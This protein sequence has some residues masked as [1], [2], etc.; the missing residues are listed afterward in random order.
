MNQTE[1]SLDVCSEREFSERHYRDRECLVNDFLLNLFDDFVD[2]NL[3]L[4][5]RL[6]LRLLE[7]WK[8]LLPAL[9]PLLRQLL[10]RSD[11]PGIP[12][13]NQPP[14]LRYELSTDVALFGSILFVE[15]SAVFF[16]ILPDLALLLLGEQCTRS[17]TPEELLEAVHD[18]LLK[19]L[20]AE[21]PYSI[22]V[23][24]L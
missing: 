8:V 22:T 7:R 4:L 9:L 19:F 20:P 17:R 5:F 24:E 12:F 6:L 15:C 14:S 1:A 3:Y 10:L 23:L 16:E 13:V 2:P 11:T 21:I 18:V